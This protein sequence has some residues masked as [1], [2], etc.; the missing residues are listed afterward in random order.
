[1]AKEIKSYLKDKDKPRENNPMPVGEY[2]VSY[3]KKAGKKSKYRS[4]K[5]DFNGIR[6]DSKFE[7]KVYEDLLFQLNL[8]LLIEIK[9]QVKIPLEV[10]GVLICNY[11]CDFRV[12]DKYGQVKYVEAK[13]M[14]LPVYAIKKKLFLALLPSIDNGAIFEEIKA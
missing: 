11:I 9:R 8:G 10:N 2:R 12:V 7:A 5:I 6:F 14:V 13:G 1:M 3:L 4:T